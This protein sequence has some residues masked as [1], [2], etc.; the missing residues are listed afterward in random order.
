MVGDISEYFRTFVFVDL[1][2]FFASNCNANKV[3]KN[4][5]SLTRLS[6]VSMFE[7]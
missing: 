3:L 5:E 7:S 4:P 2:S 6:R 1:Q